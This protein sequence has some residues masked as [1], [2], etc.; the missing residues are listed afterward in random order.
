MIPLRIE[1]WLAIVGGARRDAVEEAPQALGSAAMV[2]LLT[3]ASCAAA[4]FTAAYALANVFQ[5]PAALALAVGGGLLWA[6]FVL[7]LNRAL[8]FSV[9]GNSGVLQKLAQAVL[10]LPVA[11]AVAFS[12]SVPFTLRIC[13]EAL[14][15]QLQLERRQRIG[16]EAEALNQSSGLSDA[17]A[18]MHELN[19]FLATER[20]RLLGEPDSHEYRVAGAELEQ[21]EA[22]L[23]R[24]LES[25]QPRQDRDVALLNR[26]LANPNADPGLVE[27]LRRQ[28]A[29]L[30]RALGEARQRVSEA[31]NRFARAAVEW[32]E[33]RSRAIQEAEAEL[34]RLGPETERLAARVNVSRSASEAELE[35][36]LRPSLINRWRVLRRIASD[37]QHP[38]HEAVNQAAWGLHVLFLLLELT[39]VLAKLL[40]RPNALDHAIHALD[41]LDRER[42]TCSINRRA[43]RLQSWAAAAADSGHAQCLSADDGEYSLN[44]QSG[45]HK[46]E[47]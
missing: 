39:P 17:R 43:A 38:D 21:A 2:G 30:R 10:R 24:L 19:R 31:K 41:F 16:S 4:A 33:N 14:L 47:Q 35:K 5:G 28:I 26:L 25:L 12:I 3:L 7:A 8:I 18:R 6:G 27:A 29:E 9:D 37:P 42:I 20:E 40:A 22:G 23:A 13:D 36:I 46:D 11:V 45:G 1:K 44:L 15:I 34:A 32:R